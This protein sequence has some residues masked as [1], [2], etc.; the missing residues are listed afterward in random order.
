MTHR[1]KAKMSPPPMSSQFLIELESPSRLDDAER[2]LREVF[3]ERHGVDPENMT[4][5]FCRLEL[6][7][8]LYL[9]TVMSPLVSSVEVVEE[10]AE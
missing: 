8:D 5:T 1:I 7:P 4:V 2:A 3:A 6:H 10:V 9:V